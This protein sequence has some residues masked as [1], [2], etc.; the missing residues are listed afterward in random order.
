MNDHVIRVDQHPVAGIL[1]LDPGRMAGLPFRRSTSF[2][3]IALHLPGIA[4]RG[5]D[6]V[7]RHGRTA[8]QVN[9]HHVFGLVV[10]KRGKDAVQRS[11]HWSARA[12]AVGSRLAQGPAKRYWTGF[13]LRSARRS[14]P[15]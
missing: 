2:S 15:A 1:A 4:A 13:I 9:G 6:H 14:P 12:R 5:N 10:I 8:A 11:D 7:I 3:A